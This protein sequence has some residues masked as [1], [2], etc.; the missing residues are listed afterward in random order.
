MAS[1]LHAGRKRGWGW[2]GGDVKTEDALS[3]QRNEVSHP[4]SGLERVK[5]KVLA[6]L[7]DVT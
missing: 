4:G 3:S 1:N 7:A 2:R 6:Q 5:R